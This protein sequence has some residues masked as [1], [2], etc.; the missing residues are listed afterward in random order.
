M[1][2]TS[3]RARALFFFVGAPTCGGCECSR[4]WPTG[5][6]GEP[7]WAAPP[8]RSVLRVEMGDQMLI[9]KPFR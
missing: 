1:R 8:G 7:L 9:S 6:R 4:M 5:P 3:R 2:W